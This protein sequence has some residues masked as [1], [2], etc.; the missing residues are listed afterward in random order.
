MPLDFMKKFAV[1]VKTGLILQLIKGVSRVFQKPII[2]FN[3]TINFNIICAII[4]VCS[5]ILLILN[6]SV[7]AL[8]VLT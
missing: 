2:N 5:V 3:G 1:Q 7:I 6:R 8:L 4:F